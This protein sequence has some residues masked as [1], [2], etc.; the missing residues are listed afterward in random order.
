[1]G[2]VALQTDGE[3]EG[4]GQPRIFRNSLEEAEALDLVDPLRH[5]LSVSDS[6]SDDDTATKPRIHPEAT[7]KDT[8]KNE[9]EIESPARAND[10]RDARSSADYSLVPTQRESIINQR[11]VI[12]YFRDPTRTPVLINEPASLPARNGSDGVNPKADIGIRNGNGSGNGDGDGNEVASTTQQ[13]KAQEYWDVTLKLDMTTGCGGKIWPAAEVLGQ[14]IASRYSSPSSPTSLSTPKST[15]NSTS[16][17]TSTSEKE[18]VVTEKEKRTYDWRGKTIVE[19]GSGTGL[20]GFLVSKLGLGCRVW[21]TDQIPMLAL[22]RENLTLNP[23]PPV[24]GETCV[25]EELNWGE[26]LPPAPSPSASSALN[27]NSNST[28]VPPKPDVL[29]LA[30]CVYLESAFQPLVDTMVELS[31]KDTEILFCYQK[32]RKADKRFFGLLKKHFT[33]HDVDDDDPA[34]TLTYRRQG[35]QLLRVYRK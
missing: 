33:F 17:S 12:R 3:G 13:S 30:D 5:L 23:F 32:R 27:S 10:I 21:V 6:A 19:L 26:P 20:V 34:R 9:I 15:S 25:V 1:M 16:T 7:I 28:Q 24:P 2:D 18:G 14:Y 35:T 22:M 29:L 8:R 4:G 31:S 11:A